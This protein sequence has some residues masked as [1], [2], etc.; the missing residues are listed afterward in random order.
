MI[1][2]TVKIIQLERSVMSETK[3][4]STTWYLVGGALAL[5]WL[6]L[7]NVLR[8]DWATNSQY[9]FGWSVP[10][11]ALCFFYQK[12]SSRPQPGSL[13][14]PTLRIL[15]VLLIALA[16][17]QIPLRWL[18]EAN[19]EWRTLYWCREFQCVVLTLGVLAVAGGARWSRYFSFPVLFTATAVPWSKFIESPVTQTL[20]RA[21]TSLSAEGLFWL[22]IPA[23]RKGNLIQL[24]HGIVGVGEACSGVRSLQASL[25]LALV[26]GELWRLSATRRWLLVVLGCFSAIVLNLGR[27]FSLA[28]IAEVHGFAQMKRWHDWFGI[29][30]MALCALVVLAMAWGLRPRGERPSPATSDPEPAAAVPAISEQTPPFLG[31]FAFVGLSAWLVAEIATFSWY[32]SHEITVEP[33]WTLVRPSPGSSGLDHLEFEEVSEDEMAQL[34]TNDTLSFKWKDADK[35]SWNLSFLRWPVGRSSEACVTA[36]RP[37]LCLPAAGFGFVREKAPVEIV[38]NGVPMLF[39][40][41]LFQEND[42]LVEVF[43]LLSDL[44]TAGFKSLGSDLSIR[45]RLAAAISG[46]RNNRR[47]VLELLARGMKSDNDAARRLSVELG[48]VVFPLPIAQNRLPSPHSPNS[49]EPP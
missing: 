8:I 16:L 35:L 38:V 37:D 30:E 21:V 17:V 25:M 48:N 2:E 10:I 12:W 15:V 49:G 36:H 44:Q 47:V 11:I 4:N 43:Y 31:R 3:L 42:R 27:V 33:Q 20:M 40:D 28:V 45:G 19:A 26:G 23:L 5:Y 13:E 41:Y 9:G 22:H 29:I 18:E 14:A 46:H 32:R 6:S 1:P 24:T 7:W 34:R 39:H